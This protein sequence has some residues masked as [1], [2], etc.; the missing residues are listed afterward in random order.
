MTTTTTTTKK[1]LLRAPLLTQSGYGVHA[2]QVARWLF[3]TEQK[4]NVDITT[5]LLNWGG[6]PW[7]TNI[8]AEGGLIK[9][10]LNANVPYTMENGA[11]F[12]VTIQLQLPNEW[13]PQ[14]GKVNVGVTAG[15]EAT[16]VNPMWIDCV[17]AMTVVVVPSEFTKQGFVA[18]AA[19]VG[20]KLTTPIVVVPESFPDTFLTAKHNPNSDVSKLLSA[21]PT[22]FN[23]LF[24]GQITS[25]NVNLDRKNMYRM[26]SLLNQ[27]FGTTPDVGLIL[28]TSYIGQSRRDREASESLLNQAIRG[29]NLIGNPRIYLL[30]GGMTD[31]EM[32]DLYSHPKTKV[33]VSLTHGEGFGLPLLE[34]AAAGL[35]VMATNW[36]AHTEFLN[37]GPKWLPITANLNT[38]PAEKADGDIWIAGSEWADPSDQEFGVKI[39]KLYQGH[40]T[41]KQWAVTGAEKIKQLYSFEAVSKAYDAAITV[42]LLLG[43]GET[44]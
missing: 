19:R 41:P 31:S 25:T 40:S 27:V 21:T 3:N 43:T 28:K 24:V 5:E 7:I 30:H 22:A 8:D 44:A 16:L 13:N 1:V 2:R 39:K 20:K 32:F 10:I 11:P 29:L 37:Q 26:M 23:I 35:P 4:V 15:V 42:P 36:S 34:A 9:K 33:L 17:N 18:T 14:L 6:T 12:D 38:I